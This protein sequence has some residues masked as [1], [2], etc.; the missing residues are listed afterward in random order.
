MTRRFG[1]KIFNINLKSAPVF[2]HQ[3]IESVHQGIFDFLEMQVLPDTF[4]DTQKELKSLIGELPVVIHAPHTEQGMDMGDKDRAC[5]NYAKLRDSQ[6]MAD[7]F[8]SEVI[9][10]HAGTQNKQ[11]NI[12]ETCRQFNQINDSR[13]A[14][15]NVPCYSNNSRQELHGSSPEQIQYIM[16]ETGCLFCFDFAHAVCSANQCHRSI[17]EE[18]HAYSALKPVHF[19]LCDGDIAETEDTHLHLGKGSY[20]LAK[21]IHD[22]IPDKARVTLETGDGIPLDIQPWLKDLALARRLDK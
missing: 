18:M 11:E 16:L 3:A 9:V 19:H 4:D 20:P 10:L 15:E 7:L 2:V 13:I 8:H 21:F 1:I 22:F 17:E 5:D 6:K 14:V 12:D